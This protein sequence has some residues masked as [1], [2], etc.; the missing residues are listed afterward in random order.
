MYHMSASFDPI[1]MVPGD[2]AIVNLS[3]D[4]IQ[5]H[6]MLPCVPRAE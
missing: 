1:P 6:A 4:Y 2:V 5:Q 3:Q